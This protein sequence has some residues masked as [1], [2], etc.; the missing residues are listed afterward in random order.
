MIKVVLGY[1][2]SIKVGA[3][4]EM[5]MVGSWNKGENCVGFLFC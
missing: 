5:G 4:E 3:I 1:L 2:I